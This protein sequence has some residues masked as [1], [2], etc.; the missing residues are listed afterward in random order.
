V[1]LFGHSLIEPPTASAGNRFGNLW[2]VGGGIEPQPY[3]PFA[4]GWRQDRWKGKERR[5]QEV[6]WKNN[7][8]P[9][10]WEIAFMR[11]SS[12]ASESSEFGSTM[13]MAQK[14]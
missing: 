8:Q 2:P 10:I 12:R 9:D 6:A 5:R 4:Y 1:V 11:V 13:A 3:N 7:L 14:I